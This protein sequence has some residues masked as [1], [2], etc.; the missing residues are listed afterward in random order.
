VVR[1]FV[2]RL[3]GQAEVP[4]TAPRLVVG[5]MVGQHH[6]LAALFT[7]FTASSEGWRPIY[8]GTNLPAE[9]IAAAT[10]HCGARAAALSITYPPDDPR[11]AGELRRLRRLMPRHTAL[12]VGGSSAAAYAET[13]KEI[14]VTPLP[15][16]PA[17]RAALTRL[18]DGN[19]A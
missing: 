2:S 7:A 14:G 4:E 18:R 9:E 10:G 5:T 11:L 3:A 13:L 15:D 12:V 8:L 19:E 17:L 16:M 1:T 6:E